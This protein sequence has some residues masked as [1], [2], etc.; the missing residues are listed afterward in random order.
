VSIVAPLLVPFLPVLFSSL[1][2]F[3]LDTPLLHVHGPAAS[4]VPE[5]PRTQRRDR[6]QNED[7]SSYAR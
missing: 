3:G 7:D 1:A 2:M 6:R 4:L 5:A